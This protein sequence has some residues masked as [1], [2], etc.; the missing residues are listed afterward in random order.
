MPAD[1][2]DAAINFAITADPH[3]YDVPA[4]DFKKMKRMGVRRRPRLE[5]LKVQLKVRYDTDIVDMFK[6]T[7]DGW[8]T[9]MNDALRD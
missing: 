5:T 4:G 3:T 9:R 2:D 8:R 1:E 7:G 6:A